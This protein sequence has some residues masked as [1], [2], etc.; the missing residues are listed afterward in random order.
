MLFTWSS[1][2]N[3]QLLGTLVFLDFVIAHRDGAV[4]DL[5]DLLFYKPFMVFSPKDLQ[6]ENVNL[7]IIL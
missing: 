3:L 4:I 1:W 7:L 6:W 2:R 5:L